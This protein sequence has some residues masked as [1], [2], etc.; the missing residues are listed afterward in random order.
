MGILAIK[1]KIEE[2]ERERELGSREKLTAMG[3]LNSQFTIVYSFE[4]N[5]QKV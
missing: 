2:R 4:T 3:Y 1:T 5:V